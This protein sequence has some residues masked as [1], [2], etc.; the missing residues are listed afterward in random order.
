LA[1]SRGLGK[2]LAGIECWIDFDK[3]S[4]ELAM[5]SIAEIAANWFNSH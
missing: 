4:T 2:P 3:K 5:V 1:L